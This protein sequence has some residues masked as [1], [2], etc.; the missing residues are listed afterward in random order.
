MNPGKLAFIDHS[1]HSKTRSN[2]FLIDLL[3]KHYDVDIYFDRSWEGGSKV[4]LEV[5]A[6]EY[7]HFVFFQVIYNWDDMACIRH[8]NIIY[9]PMYD[10]VRNK[11]KKFWKEC[12]D[13]KVLC[14]CRALY[15]KLFRYGFAVKYVKYYPRPIRPHAGDRRK[16]VIYFW[17]R[18]DQFNWNHVKRLLRPE[19]VDKVIINDS[20]DPGNVFTRPPD[21][22][23]TLYNIE[24]VSWIKDGQEYYKLLSGV[25]IMLAPRLQEGIGLSFLDAMAR[26]IVVISSDRPTANEYI[27]SL[28]GYLFDIDKLEYIDIADFKIKSGEAYKM[29]EEGYSGWKLLQADLISFIEG[30]KVK[31]SFLQ[32]LFAAL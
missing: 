25:D 20:V 4:D 21:S 13:Y 30:A 16:P 2:Q 12:S 14:F 9:V 6:E 26:G 8:K 11:D 17:Q 18:T 29:L 19:Q 32:R 15:D 10:Q 22:D 24:F 3:S 27:S 23:I 28:N 31:P 7:E 1:F 5:L